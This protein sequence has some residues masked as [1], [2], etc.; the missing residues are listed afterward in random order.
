M[1]GTLG[2]GGGGASF[3]I[4]GYRLGT[5]T[6]GAPTTN[7]NNIIAAS[8]LATNGWQ[9][10]FQNGAAARDAP[11]TGA[12]WAFPIVDVFGRTL[13][14]IGVASLDL[15]RVLYGHR[16]RERAFTAGSTVIV[17]VGIGD[18]AS[19]IDASA[20]FAVGVRY[21]AATS[22]RQVSLWRCVAGV[23]TET[24]TGTADASTFGAEW[25]YSVNTTT[26]IGGQRAYPL[27]A[28]FL[29]DTV[30]GTNFVS[31]A[32]ARD[33]RAMT[34]YY[35]WAGVASATA[36][37]ASHTFDASCSLTPKEV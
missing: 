19:P 35:L 26:N 28:S 22:N 25:S 14:Q 33:G 6:P 2:G 23:W 21:P 27:D 5:T 8:A 17:G 12:C 29:A 10:T 16:V 7:P 11:D 15:A 36:D 18:N 34:H 9:L 31:D 37:G 1:R 30:P 24:G 4:G 3:Q 13:S 32:T 20:A